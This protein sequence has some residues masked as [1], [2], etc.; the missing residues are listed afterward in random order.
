MERESFKDESVASIMN[1][2][3]VN[4]KVDREE[5][6]DVDSIYMSFVQV[7]TRVDE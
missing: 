4:V 7:C 2:Y 5:R 6:P 1:E 3:F